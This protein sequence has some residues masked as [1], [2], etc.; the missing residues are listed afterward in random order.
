MNNLYAIA[1]AMI[2][3]STASFMKNALECHPDPEALFNLSHDELTNLIPKP[4]IVDAIEHRA[5]LGFA[6]E[7]IDLLEA[8]NIKAVFWNDTEFPQRLKDH[9][10]Q[11]APILLYQKGDTDLNK[12]HIVSIVGTR[13][14]T[15]YGK[16]ITR[17]LVQQLQ[18]QDLLVVSGLAMGI[19][20]CAHQACLEFGVATTGVVAHGLETIFPSQNRSIAERMIQN[21]GCILSE[22][23]YRTMVSRTFFPARNRIVAAMCDAVIVIEAASKGGALITARMGK[24]YKREIF[25][26]PGRIGDEYS[27]GCNNLISDKDAN[28]LLNGDD[29]KRHMGWGNSRKDIPSES[30]QTS[31]FEYSPEPLNLSPDEEKIYIFIKNNPSKTIDEIGNACEFSLPKTSSIL[32]NLELK[33]IITCL[34]GKTYKIL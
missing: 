15:E 14:C 33:S 8:N 17:R 24:D 23:P 16:Q 13:Q 32:L 26:I 20:A 2:P 22:H 9:Q 27:E 25:A 11:N 34:P 5:T 28:I 18:E 30:L 12:K 21:G 6:Q 19:D 29:L 1:L 10:C 3:G 31:L 4:K 7:E